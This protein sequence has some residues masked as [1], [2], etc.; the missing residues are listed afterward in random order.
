MK[1]LCTAQM[2]GTSALGQVMRVIAVAKALRHKGHEVKF[3]AGDKISD[4]VKNHQLEVI[5]AS[6]LPKINISF[7]NLA[8]YE[9]HREEIMSY[10]KEVIKH[11]SEEEKSVIVAEKP[12][13]LLSGN[14]TGPLTAKTLGLPNVFIFL[15]PHGEKTVELF[16]RRMTEPIKKHIGQV[17]MAANLLLMEG[18]PELGGDE[19]AADA[20]QWTGL[21]DK[22]RFTGPLL[23]EQPEQLPEQAELKQ[24]HAGTQERPL[25]YVTI[26]GGTP[27]I[28]ESF[29]RLVL[30]MFRQ[31]PEVQ[32]LIATGLA[33]AP[34]RLTDGNLPEN[35]LVRGFV[36]GTELVKASD[37]TVF[38]GGSSTLMTCI[39]C[40]TP[41][42]VVPSMAEQEDNGAVLAQNKAGIMLDKQ[43]LS[44]AGLAEA[45]RKI[46]SDSEFKANAQ[47]LKA[48]GDQ[49]GGPPA[50]AAMIEALLGE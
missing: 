24:R 30:D 20:E 5:E 6:P 11:I 3:L 36:P 49:Y 44:A 43:D 19:F 46:L 25:V 28:G 7:N 50:A 10:V 27:L 29:L 16:T 26:G 2:S 14:L 39:A 17:I 21:K 15:Q 23:A 45:I 22:I 38:H 8:E 12:D 37:V 48:I 42:V 9:G 34:D 1:V 33:L 40:G 13:V 32:G 4:V 31:L 18:M 41:A 47:R 35:V